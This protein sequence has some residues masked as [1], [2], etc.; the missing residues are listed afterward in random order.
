MM[1]DVVLL[2]VGL[3]L[4]VYG[5]NW[6]VEGASSIA[7]KLG[8]SAFV[9]G[10]TV[11]AFGTS[12][13][14]LVVNIMSSIKGN[15]GLAIGN[16]VGSNTINVLVVL[17][18]SALI[19]PIKVKSSTIRIEIPYSIFAAAILFLL[20]NDVLIDGAS[21]SILS[22]I[23]GVVLLSFLGIF[24]YYT[25]LS[26]KDAKHIAKG[27]V[28]E[29]KMK[30]SL[31]LI[32]AGIVGLYL[33]G[34]LIVDSATQIAQLMGVPDSIIGLTIVALGTSLP[35]LVTSAVAAYKG[36]ADIAVGNVL[37]SNIFNICMVLGISSLI[38]P[39]PFYPQANIDILM[40][41]FA[42]LL[43]LVFAFAGPGQRIDRKEGGLFVA[44]Y[45]GYLVYVIMSHN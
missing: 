32:F 30:I 1:L 17:G 16:I 12:M 6:L 25:F 20:A 15:S 35:E 5:A 24:F 23:D 8:V 42:S 29:R 10:L 19:R 22:R 7:S 27:Y 11:V 37:G 18:I 13:P 21:V 40:T 33:G 36:N 31:L 26:S 34:K 38:K 39:L 14:E 44:V 3:V 45:V 4:L 43:L 28:K 9:V 2:V 41:G